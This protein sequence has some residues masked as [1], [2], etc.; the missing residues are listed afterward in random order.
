MKRIIAG[1]ALI[2]LLW[3]WVSPVAAHPG[4][5][6]PTLLAFA[7]APQ[8][9]FTVAK[10]DIESYWKKNYSKETILEINPA[11]AGTASE[12]IINLK[13]VPYYSVPARVKVKRTDG[14]VATFSVSSIYK[15]PADNWIFEDV[16]T[17][18][19][20]QEKASAQDAPPFVEAE[21]L[22]AKGWV[23]KFS[24]EGDSGIKILKVH[25]GPAF[26]AYGQRF[27]YRYR[28]DVEYNSGNTR[29]QC[30]GQEAD[31]VK[32]N[33]GA[34]WAFKALKNSPSGACQGRN[35]K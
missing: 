8:V 3:I 6:V 9:A 26:K 11:G 32:E 31:L 5:V 7:A 35:L 20:Q 24:Q 21:A 10:K 23:D 2:A 17:G 34:P 27:W 4:A 33:A 19:V 13:K 18:N 15:K 1:S 22:I 30:Q 12:K 16:A 28:I 29:Y 14:S 25:P